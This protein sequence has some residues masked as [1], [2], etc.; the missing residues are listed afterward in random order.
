[1][2]YIYHHRYVQLGRKGT[3]EFSI[4]LAIRKM[5]VIEMAKLKWVYPVTLYEY[6]VLLKNKKNFMEISSFLVLN[7]F[8]LM[9]LL[10]NQA[11]HSIS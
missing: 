4:L 10:V 3:P 7:I 9:E 2:L 1:M 11:F 6:G 8:F 5:Y